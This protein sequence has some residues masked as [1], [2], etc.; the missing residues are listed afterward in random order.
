[1][2]ISLR[3]FL[4]FVA[5][6]SLCTNVLAVFAKEVKFDFKFGG[7]GHDGGKFSDKTLFSFDQEGAIYIA[8]NGK[9]MRKIQK[10]M[11]DGTLDFT[12][13]SEPKK[14]V[15]ANI[16]DMAIGIDGKIYVSDWKISPIEGADDPKLFTYGA[17]IH[18]FDAE[19]QFIKT[20]FVHRL[21]HSGIRSLPD[22]PLTDTSLPLTHESL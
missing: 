4:S 13:K 3:R 10:L 2:V 7:K 16:T 11:P 8:D 12:I 20:Y 19:G 21:T 1:M 22:S 6:I 17:C 18:K 14:F 15:F 9:G 5:V